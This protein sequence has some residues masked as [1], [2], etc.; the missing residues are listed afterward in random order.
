MIPAII[1]A[2][3]V[4]GISVIAY[5]LQSNNGESQTQFNPPSDSPTENKLGLNIY[6]SLFKVTVHE[7]DYVI[8]NNTKIWNHAEFELKPELA[9]LYDEI[10][11]TNHPQNTIV[12]NPVFT[13]MAYSDHGFYS[14]YRGEC[15]TSCLTV[16]I[17]DDPLS[18]H[19]SENGIKILKLLGYSFITDIDVDKNPNILSKYDKVILLHNEYVTKKE[20][21]AITSHPNVIYLYPNSL[22]AEIK[23]DY[24]ANTITLI[25]GH[26]YPDKEIANGFGWKFDNTNYEADNE[27]KDM[28]FYKIDNGYMLN[29]YPVGMIYKGKLL[30]KQIKDF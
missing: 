10:G 15:D 13:A 8:E 30:L 23:A 18:Y 2:V 6:H 28:F 5:D 1:A 21:D 12:I 4:G 26:S 29:C 20:F 16:K 3:I 27:C 9:D 19:S 24:D 14:Y 17:A 25:R 22:F 11:V 7:N